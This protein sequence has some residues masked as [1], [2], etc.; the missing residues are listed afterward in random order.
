MKLTIETDGTREGTRAWIEGHEGERVKCS[1]RLAQDH[2]ESPA[3]VLGTLVPSETMAKLSTPADESGERRRKPG[4]RATDRGEP[5][6]ALR[7][8]PGGAPASGSDE[9][10]EKGE[11]ACRER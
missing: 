6:V 5:S 9:N 3:M 8:I 11:Q 2:G 10:Q 7:L 1:V 4:R